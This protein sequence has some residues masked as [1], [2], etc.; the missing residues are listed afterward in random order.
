L[1]VLIV[2]TSC[3]NQKHKRN[4]FHNIK[5]KNIY[6]SLKDISNKTRYDTDS[7]HVPIF[8]TSR[9]RQF[10]ADLTTE[11]RV[12]P[13]TVHV[14][15]FGSQYNCYRWQRTV[16][17]INGV[18]RLLSMVIDYCPLL[19]IEMCYLNIS[20]VDKYRL[21]VSLDVYADW[22]AE[23]VNITAVCLAIVTWFVVVISCQGFGTKTLLLECSTY[24]CI[25]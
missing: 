23:P 18:Y 15:I 7:Q 19:P 14:G 25:C 10:V 11:K 4:P 9:F 6:I 12:D 16:G 5:Y 17:F 24:S 22:L 8:T 13:R 3:K 2:L 1:P 20:T 21:S